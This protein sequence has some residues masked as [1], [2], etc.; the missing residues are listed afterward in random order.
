MLEQSASTR[1]DPTTSPEPSTSLRM[2]IM[3]NRCSH[4][5]G[6]FRSLDNDLPLQTAHILLLIAMQPGITVKELM[7]RAKLSQS[8]CSRNIARLSKTNRHG[9]PGYD[10]VEARPDPTDSRRHKL[11]LTE[12]GKE[13]AAL[14]NDT[15]R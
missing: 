13:F 11:Y 4:F 1:D 3:M 14:V 15:L 2:K 5:L 10:M 9:E 6:Q 8:S 12:K 7:A